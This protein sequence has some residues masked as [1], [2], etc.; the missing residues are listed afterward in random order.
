MS[1]QKSTLTAW[2]N[3]TQT[4]NTNIPITLTTS[5]K[6]GCSILFNNGSTS[7]TLDKC[8]LYYINVS[9]NAVEGGTAGDI[10]LQLFNNSIPV[11]SALA[12]ETSGTATDVVNLSFSKI[13]EVKPSCPAI[14]NTSVLTIVN[15]G[16]DAIYSNIIVNI[17]KL[18]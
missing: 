17:F 18:A 7:I 5:T 11:T 16:I 14:N 4:L 12:T 3:T 10:T 1:F 9:A 15:T 2:T 6:T 8:G 13:I